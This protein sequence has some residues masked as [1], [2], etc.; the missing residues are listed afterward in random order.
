MQNILKGIIGLKK[1]SAVRQIHIIIVCKYPPPYSDETIEKTFKFGQYD[2]A[3]HNDF[4]DAVTEAL[5]TFNVVE[6][7]I[8][9]PIINIKG[10]LAEDRSYKTPSTSPPKKRRKTSLSTTPSN[11]EQAQA[12]PPTYKAFNVDDISWNSEFETPPKRSGGGRSK[13][14]QKTKKRLISKKKRTKKILLRKKKNKK[15]LSKK[16]DS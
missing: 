9:I 11:E 16:K 2:D 7:H 12:S 1:L 4:F 14:R 15:Q 6:L 3:S 8:N 10:L 5:Q 13:K